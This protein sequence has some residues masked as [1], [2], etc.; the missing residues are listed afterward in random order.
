[1]SKLLS[2]IGMV[3]S[4][5][6]CWDCVLGLFLGAG[7]VLGPT[8]P[9]PTYHTSTA[10]QSC[11]SGLC[12][13][14]AGSCAPDASLWG[15]FA[16]VIVEEQFPSTGSLA[17]SS[18][19]QATGQWSPSKISISQKQVLGRSPLS[20]LLGETRK[21]GQRRDIDLSK[22]SHSLDGGWEAGLAAGAFNSQLSPI[23][24]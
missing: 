14:T 11:T 10:L 6:G 5:S 16:I 19:C 22:G 12:V 2:S 8:S 20:A 18:G 24:R 4:V 21:T 17:S 7:T 9:Y 3:K 15:L 23:F 13:A 1:M